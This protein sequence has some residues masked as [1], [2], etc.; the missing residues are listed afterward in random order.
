MVY[1]MLECQLVVNEFFVGDMF[2]IVDCV[3]VLGLFY[4]FV[5]YLWD[6]GAHLY[7]MCYYCV[8]VHWLFFVKVIVDV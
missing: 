4:V 3:V 5:I 8:L 7:L 2:M 6:E 1:G